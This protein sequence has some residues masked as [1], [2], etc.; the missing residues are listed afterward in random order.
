LTKWNFDWTW[1]GDGKGGCDLAHVS[2]GFRATVL[3]PRLMRPQNLDPQLA[4]AWSRFI[5]TLS[6][7]EAG[8][9]RHAY[10]HRE[11]VANAIRTSTC[12]NANAA[13]RAAIAILSQ[14]DV[15][16]DAATR[17]GRSQGVAFP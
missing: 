9:V 11:D 12:E 14:Y 15:D 7:H 5:A 1:P 17:H 16:Y 13:A 2:V 4:R 10:E 6:L 8:H 3:L